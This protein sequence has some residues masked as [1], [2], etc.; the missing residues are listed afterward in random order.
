MAYTTPWGQLPPHCHHTRGCVPEYQWEGFNTVQI[1]FVPVEYQFHHST[2]IIVFQRATLD[3]W[4]CGRY[5]YRILFLFTLSWNSWYGHWCNDGWWMMMIWGL[6]V[7]VSSQRLDLVLPSGKSPS[8]PNW[9][10]LQLLLSFRRPTHRYQTY[11]SP[12]GK[13][14]LRES[15]YYKLVWPYCRYSCIFSIYVVMVANVTS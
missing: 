15:Y 3:G 10:G 4:E 14:T 1:S 9:R 11:E 7:Q 12:Q 13:H 8:P 6:W 2:N 5:S